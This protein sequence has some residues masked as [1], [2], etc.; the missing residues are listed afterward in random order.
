[1]IWQLGGGSNLAG[2]KPDGKGLRCECGN[3]E[4]QV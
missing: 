4:K 3:E 1:M 2:L